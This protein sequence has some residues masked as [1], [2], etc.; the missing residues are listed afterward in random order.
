MEEHDLIAV[1]FVDGRP[2]MVRAGKPVYRQ[3][4]QRL[5]SGK[6]PYRIVQVYTTDIPPRRPCLRRHL[7]D[8]SSKRAHSEGR[9]RY[10][11]TGAG[12]LATSRDLPRASSW[13]H[14]ADRISNMVWSDDHHRRSWAYSH[15]LALDHLPGRRHQQ[16]FAFRRSLSRQAFRRARCQKD[17]GTREDGKDCS[18][19]AELGSG[20]RGL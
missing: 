8:R 16:D 4:F 6:Y 3:A 12:A 7:S 5:V 17:V 19:D 1:S 15:A 2:S 10:Q 9:F 11:S 13:Y 14:Q 20:N 18:K